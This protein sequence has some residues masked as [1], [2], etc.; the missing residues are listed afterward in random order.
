MSENRYLVMLYSQPVLQAVTEYLVVKPALALFHL[1]YSDI[2]RYDALRLGLCLPAGVCQ[3][4][5]GQS[6]NEIS[7]SS[8]WDRGRRFGLGGRL[9]VTE[10][11]RP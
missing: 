2:F 1:E 11:Q 5:S 8:A 4:S 3:M 9:A 7:G 6:G 10:L